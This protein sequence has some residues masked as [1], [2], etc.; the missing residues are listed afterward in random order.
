[1]FYVYQLRVEN[2][3]LPF[4]VGKGHKSR[5]FEHTRPSSL[6]YDSNTH[7]VNIIRKAQRENKNILIEFLD[8]NLSESEAFRYEMYYISAYGRCDKGLGQL[9]NMTDG[10][11][12][13]SGI[14]I[15]EEHK[16]RIS[17][18][19]S[20]KNNPMYG[21]NHSLESNALRSKTWLEN[22]VGHKHTE[23]TKNKL[24]KAKLGTKESEL[25]CNRKSIALKGRKLDVDRVERSAAKRRGKP[26]NKLMCPHCNVIGGNS[27]M[28]R[29]HFDKCK[30]LI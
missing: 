6:Q 12:G 10:G 9:S 11:D 14:I 25:T 20:G 18:A 5:A 8:T 24:S 15:S 19:N 2:N 13:T 27:A 28:K 23:Q 17:V 3:A 22:N 7:K 30:L 26:A 21:V 29:W 1:M 4:Y 16:K